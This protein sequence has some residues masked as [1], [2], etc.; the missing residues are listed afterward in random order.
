MANFLDK[1]GLDYYT[2]G[3]AKKFAKTSDVPTKVSELENDS[4]YLVESDVSALRTSVST[5]TSDITSLKSTKADK[6]SL[7]TVATSGSYNDLSNKPT[8]PTVNNAK[9]T[10]QKNGTTVKTFTA[11]ASTDVTA[12]ITVPTKVSELTNDSSY[13]KSGDLAT[14]ATSGSYNDLSNKPTIPTVNNATLTIQK[15]GTSVGTFTANASTNATANITV[16]TKVSELTNDSSYAKTTDLATVATS[17]SYSDLSNKPTIPAAQ[18]NSDWNATSGLAQILNKPT[19]PTKTSQLTNDSNYA[20]T[21]AIPTKTSQ[22]TNNGADGTSTYVEAND[23]STVATSGSYSDLS[24]KPTIPTKTS[25]LTND[26][27]YATSSD[28]QTAVASKQDKLTAGDHISITDNTISATDYVHSEDP[29]AATTTT[30]VVSNSMVVDGTLTFDKTATGEFLQLTL[31][32]T[33]IGAGAALAA[34]TL[35]GVYDA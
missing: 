4:N 1:D 16:P 8:I 18:V 24:G 6:S 2:K 20:T 23:L 15:N 35:Y 3:L 33:D 30:Q 14:V 26:S 7:A 32:T 34:N 21:S 31:S 10:I 5:N 13:A 22:L 28:I 11:N 12:N 17:G 19:I 25:Q 29:V 27:N 9:L